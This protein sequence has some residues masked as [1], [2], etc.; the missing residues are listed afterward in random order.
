MELFWSK[1]GWTCAD[2]SSSSS[3][4]FFV[5]FLV[6]EA[7]ITHSLVWLPIIKLVSIVIALRSDCLS[8]CVRGV[9]SLCLMHHGLSRWLSHFL[10]ELRHSCH[11]TVSKRLFG[12]MH[13]TSY[14]VQLGFE[15][16]LTS[17]SLVNSLDS[18][19]HTSFIIELNQV[20]E[21][22]RCFQ[23]IFTEREVRCFDN[24]LTFLQEGFSHVQKLV[25][26]DYVLSVTYF[27]SGYTDFCTREVVGTHLVYT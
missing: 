1:N 24:F 13:R 8:C 11:R 10:G 25:L 27:S 16:P 4:A 5:Q 14:L 26:L 2:R 7:V 22:F 19:S 20:I 21:N 23:V 12:S 9:T 6:S 15:H 18:G 3:N 17:L